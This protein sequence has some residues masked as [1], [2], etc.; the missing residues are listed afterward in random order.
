[1]CLCRRT[2]LELLC[3]SREH[4][5]RTVEQIDAIA[6]ANSLADSKIEFGTVTASAALNLHNGSSKHTQRSRAVRDLSI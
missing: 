4:G 2:P 5:A 6:E 1:M 3:E